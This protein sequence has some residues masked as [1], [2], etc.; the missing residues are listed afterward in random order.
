MIVNGFIVVTFLLEWKTKQSLKTTDTVLMCL[1]FTRRLLNFFS[2]LGYLLQ[3]S[4]VVLIILN[5]ISY[6]LNWSGLWFVSLLS[7]TYCVKIT[8]FNNCLFIYMKLNISKLLNWLI[9]VN[10]LTSL[11]FTILCGFTWKD[12]QTNW[13]N[14]TGSI[15][16]GST[17][18]Y[19]NAHIN[20]IKKM[21]FSFVLY[22][23][24]FVIDVL[25][26]VGPSYTFNFI[27][28]NVMSAF[29]TLIHSGFVIYSDTRL[30]NM[31]LDMSRHVSNCT[32]ITN[33][34]E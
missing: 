23:V 25:T 33:Q 5:Y 3:T 27:F 10:L 31:F 9:L 19:V 26:F 34:H 6:Y 13:I 14:S 21:V 4:P 29:Y 18:T 28:C 22:I 17:E 20:I 12:L 30:K 7:V 24:Y 1:G 11:A 32:R 2:T 16:N 8:T 15:L